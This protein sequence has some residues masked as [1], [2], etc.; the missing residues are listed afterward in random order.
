MKEY[1]IKAYN[2]NDFILVDEEDFSFLSQYN[3]SVTEMEYVWTKI[4]GITTYMHRLIMNCPENLT[5]D[6]INHNPLDNRK[7]ELRICT[8]S[9][10]NYNRKCGSKNSASKYKGVRKSSLEN[11]WQSEVVFEGKTYLVGGFYTQEYSAL[12]YDEKA[13]ELQ[14]VYAYLNNISMTKE[15]IIKL[16]KEA[17]I[18]YFNNINK[19]SKYRYVSYN[20]TVGK[21]FGQKWINK[22]II[23]TSFYNTEEEAHKSILKIM[24]DAI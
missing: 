11:K 21:W 6:H 20:K 4:N 24:E 9:Q 8:Y 5:V 17:E 19:L 22:K 18:Q 13:K 1:K 3:W 10:N 16:E 15:E 2:T 23:R 12:M 14:G 7:S